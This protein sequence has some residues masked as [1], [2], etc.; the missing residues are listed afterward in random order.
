[1]PLG[2]AALTADAKFRALLAESPTYPGTLSAI[3]KP[4]HTGF[5]PLMPLIPGSSHF[6]FNL[7][8]NRSYYYRRTNSGYRSLGPDMRDYLMLPWSTVLYI[9]PRFPSPGRWFTY[10]IDT[11]PQPVQSHCLA[12]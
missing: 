4:P 2:D 8:S 1:M 7:S 12:M 5:D 3:S 6:G 10:V 9:A 11:D